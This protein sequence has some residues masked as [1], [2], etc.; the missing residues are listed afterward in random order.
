ME[1]QKNG[2]YFIKFLDQAKPRNVISKLFLTL[3]ITNKT[4][5]NAIVVAEFGRC[6][7]G[8]ARAINIMEKLPHHCQDNGVFF[9]KQDY[10][11]L[12]MMS[13]GLRTTFKFNKIPDFYTID[14]QEYY[15]AE[16]KVAG[17]KVGTA[18]LATEDILNVKMQEVE[19]GQRIRN[20]NFEIPPEANARKVSVEVFNGD[21]IFVRAP[22]KGKYV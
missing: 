21:T 2:I 4:S 22:L 14:D 11:D 15:A 8:F 19:G 3:K 20:F 12:D 9:R 18:A 6:Y 17:L 13:D 10:M 16:I 1:K 5:Y 7:V